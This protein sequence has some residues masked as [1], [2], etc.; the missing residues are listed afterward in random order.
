MTMNLSE[1]LRNL[2]SGEWGMEETS[3]ETGVRPEMLMIYLRSPLVR[4]V[5]VEGGDGREGTGRGNGG[6]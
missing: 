4:A 3:R 1:K 5:M 2:S 6:S